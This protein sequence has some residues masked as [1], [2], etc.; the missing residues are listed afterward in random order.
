MYNTLGA[1]VLNKAT[2]H[3]QAVKSRSKEWREIG[4]RRGKK[5][6]WHAVYIHQHAKFYGN[7][8]IGFLGPL[9]TGTEAE[10]RE[11]FECADGAEFQPNQEAVPRSVEHVRVQALMPENEK[12]E[13]NHDPP[14]MEVGSVYLLDEVA[15]TALIN[16]FLDDE[17]DL[18]CDLFNLDVMEGKEMVN[19]TEILNNERESKNDLD[20]IQQYGEYLEG[21]L[22]AAVI[23]YIWTLPYESPRYDF[24]KETQFI[25][26]CLGF[27]LFVRSSMYIGEK[28]D[29]QDAEEIENTGSAAS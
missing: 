14:C 21:C 5:N 12:D 27:Y 2:G 1:S 29:K 23:S 13:A 24:F 3:L 16:R 9:K 19:G 11:G 17:K 18:L 8:D 28:K 20:G 4:I 6:S 22:K 10:L 26:D 15:S 7:Q 25:G